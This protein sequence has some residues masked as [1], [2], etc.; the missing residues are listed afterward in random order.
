MEKSKQ[1]ELI[2]TDRFSELT[3][4]LSG[5]TDIAS[6][7]NY[8]SSKQRQRIAFTKEEFYEFEDFIKDKDLSNDQRSLAYRIL[9][10]E[11]AL[12]SDFKD[13]LDYINLSIEENPSNIEAI[14]VKID[15]CEN[16]GNGD[17]IFK[18]IN[19]IFPKYKNDV[20]VLCIVA[21]YAI[22]YGKQKQADY[23]FKQAVKINRLYTITR[24]DFYNYWIALNDEE[25]AIGYA[26]E[27]IKY[28][29]YDENIVYCMAKGAALA[30]ELETSL[31]Y[32]EKYALMKDELSDQEKSQ[33]ADALFGC[34]KF[35]KAFDVASTI[36]KEYYFYDGIKSFLQKNLYYIAKINIDEAKPR[37]IKWRSENLDDVLI[38]HSCDAIIGD[39]NKQILDPMYAKQFFDAFAPDFEDVLL[40]K[41]N[42]K[43]PEL[44][45][46]LFDSKFL[47]ER[48]FHSIL[49]LGCGTGLMGDFLHEKMQFKSVLTGVDVSGAML[50]EARKKAVYN[51][52]IQK[53]I[54]TFLNE[55]EH[56]Y[57][58][59]C[60]MDVF[61]YFAD[62]NNV[63]K[64][65]Y[66]A[67]IPSGIF[68]FEI[69]KNKNDE[70][71]TLGYNGQF[72]HNAEIMDNFLH[73]LKFK[74][75]IRKETVLRSELDI[76]ENC[77][78]YMV[79]K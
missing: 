18:L 16:L 11:C 2:F 46:E 69:L 44:L 59:I 34:K 50:D 14:L 19:S 20:R 29:P 8:F 21:S 47:K 3:E 31:E 28:N 9:A 60:C 23:L 68:V 65:I 36:S 75:L 6:V 13:A 62:L 76:Q 22:E 1:L 70:P 74:I 10:Q 25:K 53:D 67:M 41:L 12:H 54:V 17:E 15:L 4:A 52:L 39:N 27:A 49:D 45:I 43:G 66:D 56:K 7:I 37:A 78:V 5:K 35:E 71:Y 24:A 32:F 40:G 42:Y 33:W 57:D 77:V 61:S 55:A 51:K 72:K 26:K 73:E 79:E 38:C 58:F 30:G 64:Q 48:E 63:I